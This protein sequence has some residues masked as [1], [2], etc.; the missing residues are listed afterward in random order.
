MLLYGEP[1]FIEN[2]IN[3]I[4]ITVLFLIGLWLLKFFFYSKT[5]KKADH[6]YQKSMNKFENL[7]YNTRKFV[8]V[9]SMIV[10]CLVIIIVFIW[11]E[12]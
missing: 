12:S 6:V 2:W 3:G 8:G 9:F 4:V 10:Y 5:G 7:P 11:V 1:G